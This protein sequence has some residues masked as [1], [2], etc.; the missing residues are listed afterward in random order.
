MPTISAVGHEIDLTVCD[1]VAD[2]RAATPSAAAEAAVPAE[3]DLFARL[4]AAGA[5]LA[6]AATRRIRDAHSTL[7]RSARHVHRSASVSVERRAARLSAAAARVQALSPLAT[8]ARGYAVARD[9][10][11]GPA[12]TTAA[13]F[14]PG[15]PFDLVLIDGRVRARV[16]E[17]AS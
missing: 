3:S 10:N 1:L 5:D 15:R 9:I 16:E 14:A 7:T 8:L 2:H 11:G 17:E 6:A 4:H 13:Q 12:L